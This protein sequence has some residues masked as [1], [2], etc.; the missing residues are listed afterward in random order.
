MR[1]DTMDWSATPADVEAAFREPRSSDV[2]AAP[3]CADDLAVVSGNETALREGLER[4]RLVIRG[5]TVL[6]RDGSE[7]VGV[8]V[9]PGP[10][11][12]PAVALRLRPH[13]PQAAAIA[14]RIAALAPDD[15]QALEDLLGEAERS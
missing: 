6:S 5:R 15:R 10:G 8:F 7:L 3:E 2:P 9:N 14:A 4:L 11:R 1:G 12:T 13:D